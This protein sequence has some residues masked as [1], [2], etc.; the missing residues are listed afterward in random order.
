[1]KPGGGG[2]GGGSGI[3]VATLERSGSLLG[4]KGQAGSVKQDPPALSR[5]AWLLELS[6][7]PTPPSMPPTHQFGSQ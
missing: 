2:G 3:K 4:A 5:Q 7:T 6:P 1:M